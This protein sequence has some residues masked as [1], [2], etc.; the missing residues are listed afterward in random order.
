MGG[1]ILRT[2]REQE[3]MSTLFLYIRRWADTLPENYITLSARNRKNSLFIHIPV[4]Q[5]HFCPSATQM[6]FF[7]YY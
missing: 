5:L 1:S 4:Y 7:Y 6:S 2:L 3:K